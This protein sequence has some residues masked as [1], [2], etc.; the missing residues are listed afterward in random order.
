MIVDNEDEDEDP[1]VCFYKSKNFQGSALC[2]EPAAAK[3]AFCSRMD[4]AT[5]LTVRPRWLRRSGLIQMR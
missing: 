5:S 3:M 1:E 2:T 4:V